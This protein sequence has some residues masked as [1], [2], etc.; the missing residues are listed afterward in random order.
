MSRFVTQLQ[1]Q[2]QQQGQ[3]VRVQFIVASDSVAWIK[4]AINFTSIAHQLNQTSTNN[5]VAVDV[6]HSEGHDPG[7]DLALMS[8]CDGVIMS[9]GTYGW[10][11]AW[12]ANKTTVYYS[13]WPRARS[14]LS[15]LFR[16][17][18][19]FPPNWIPI[20]GPEFPS[21]LLGLVP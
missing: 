17:D 13:N 8:L 6:A 3:E 20:G 11:G 7:F 9:T 21:K 2:E 4:S 18:D 5:T 16:R 12:L 15:R 1:Q 10:W 14:A 19:F